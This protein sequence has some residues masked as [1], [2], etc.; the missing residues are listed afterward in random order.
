[1]AVWVVGG[2][3]LGCDVGVET[4]GLF[5]ERGFGGFFGFVAVGFGAGARLRVEPVRVRGGKG[6]DGS[7][8]GGSVGDLR[9]RSS[10]AA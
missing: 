1:M 7:G 5:P 2:E 6:L 9:L 4:V 8:D 3:G 10:R